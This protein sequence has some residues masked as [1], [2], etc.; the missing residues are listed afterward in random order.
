MT[1]INK[2]NDLHFDS[3]LMGLEND[4]LKCN[5]FKEVYLKLEESKSDDFR[6]KCIQL[7][8]WSNRDFINKLSGFSEVTE[9]EVMV[10]NLIA[11]NL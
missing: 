9:S 4:K 11:E 1:E 6:I 5:L 7:L 2:N 3:T 10:I 8:G